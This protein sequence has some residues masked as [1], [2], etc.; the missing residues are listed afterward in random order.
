M[1]GNNSEWLETND[2]S[3]AP[4]LCL[5]RLLVQSD[6]QAKRCRP[7]TKAVEQSSLLERVQTFIPDLRE[8]NYRL[9][10]KL[11]GGESVGME[12]LDEEPAEAAEQRQKRP[13]ERKDE[14]VEPHIELTLLYDKSM[15]ELVP[16]TESYEKDKLGCSVPPERPLIEVIQNTTPAQSTGL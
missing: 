14:T 4:R 13:G 12:L 7:A 8:A 10:M 6:A 3:R 16:Y 11:K 9:E 15:G 1:K 2:D 5:E